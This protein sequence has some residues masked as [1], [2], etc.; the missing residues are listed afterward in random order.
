VRLVEFLIALLEAHAETLK[1]LAALFGEENL[2]QLLEMA[3][4]EPSSKNAASKPAP[5]I[6]LVHPSFFDAP[7]PFSATD[8]TYAE[9]EFAVREMNLPAFLEFHLWAY[10]H[11]RAFIESPIDLNSRIPGPGGDAGVALVDEAVTQAEAWVK[12]LPMSDLV[13][14]QASRAA[15][16]PWLKF[17]TQVLKRIGK[18]P[19]GPVY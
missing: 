5:P 16:V 7:S 3:G 8:S 10:P 4:D 18:R 1:R 9:I 19:M 14:D 15:H 11:Y 12:G 17:R 6:K 2:I 13:R